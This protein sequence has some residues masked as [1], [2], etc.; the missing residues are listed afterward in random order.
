VYRQ[1]IVLIHYLDDIRSADL[2]HIILG[3]IVYCYFPVQTY[4]GSVKKALVRR[5]VKLTANRTLPAY[6]YGQNFLMAEK[7]SDA[8]PP[9]LLESYA[10]PPFIKKRKVE[11]S[12]K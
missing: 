6:N 3:F 1:E 2:P 11:A 10:V 8:A 7:R 5:A 9:G 12:D 4:T